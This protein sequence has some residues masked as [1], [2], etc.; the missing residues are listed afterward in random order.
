MIP[1]FFICISSMP[2]RTKKQIEAD[3][4][5]LPGQK[6]TALQIR[7]SKELAKGREVVASTSKAQGSKE[8]K[9]KSC[10]TKP[11]RIGCQSKL[12]GNAA[13]ARSNLS[14]QS[15]VVSN[16]AKPASIIGAQTKSL[17]TSTQPALKQKPT[18]TDEPPLEDV[19]CKEGV[20][21]SPRLD[22]N[23][24]DYL[25]KLM[26]KKENQ[27]SLFGSGSLTNVD[28]MTRA[29]CWETLAT[30]VNVY[31]NDHNRQASTDSQNKMKLGGSEMMKRW[32]RIK[33]Q[34]VETKR[35]FDTRTGTGLLDRDYEN[36]IDSTEKKKNLMCPRYETIDEIY[37]HKSNISP[38][39]T[40]DTARSNA[41]SIPSHDPKE[42]DPTIDPNLEAE[43]HYTRAEVD[44][45]DHNDHHSSSQIQSSPHPEPPINFEATEGVILSS[46]S[47]EGG[48]FLELE[49]T[50]EVENYFRH[51]TPDLP[52]PKAPTPEP[53]SQ[54]TV[55]EED[56]ELGNDDEGQS[57]RQATRIATKRK[58]GAEPMA[59]R[60]MKPL[61]S[62]DPHPGRHR[63]P[64]GSIMED[65]DNKRFDYFDR[66]TDE[67]RKK[68]VDQINTQ[69]K[70]AGNALQWDKQKYNKARA[71]AQQ[72]EVQK[73]KIESELHANQI[74]WE[75]EKF[76]KEDARLSKAE[77]DRVELERIKTRR[78][79]MEACQVKGMSMVDIKEYM[80]VLF[81]K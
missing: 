26:A 32:K 10:Q 4:G 43:Y 79:V 15:N 71:D 42:E 7:E 27:D 34:Y 39:A 49:Q 28:G 60:V 33:D 1:D 59:N 22:E 48:M 30:L 56:V 57:I 47:P 19:E 54:S 70:I 36:G 73:A 6:P 41:I 69:A 51:S 80:D 17:A 77:D 58:R 55:P 46:Q 37:G 67:K 72:A 74:L 68:E 8:P 52:T 11:P 66:K 25:L 61:P 9:I 21:V 29:G 62:V 20:Y 35:Y 23:D 12:V 24:F 5:L 75:R 76:T 53:N 18:R 63:A 44:L 14:T 81:S 3:C 64:V 16:S 2:R 31:H 38:H 65:R 50:E 13:K 45:E 40:I 78:E